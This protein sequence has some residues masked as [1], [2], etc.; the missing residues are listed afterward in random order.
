MLYFEKVKSTLKKGCDVQL[1]PRTVI[2]GPNGSGKSTIVQSIE[3]AANGWASDMEGRSR[4]KQSAALARLFPGSPRKAEAVMSDGT[5]FS[6]E[7]ED[8]TRP[9]SFKKPD[10]T[11]PFSVRWPVQDLMEVLRGDAS[12][13]GAWLEKQVVGDL[14]EED[15]LSALPPAVRGVVADFVQQKSQ[16]DFIALAKMANQQAK[17]LRSQATRSEKTIEKMTEGIAPPLLDSKRKELEESLAAM[18]APRHGSTQEDYDLCAAEVQELVDKFVEKTA[19]LEKLSPLPEAVSVALERLVAAND[20]IKQHKKVFGGDE[21]WVCG[22]EQRLEDQEARLGVAME[23]LKPQ[24]LESIN[25]QK[26]QQ[27][28]STL[29]K[30]MERKASELKGMEVVDPV[31]DTARRD[32]IAKIAADDSNRKSWSNADAAGKEVEQMRAKADLL[33]LAGGALEKAGKKFLAQR[34]QAFEDRVSEHLPEGER[35]GVDLASSR[36]G[37][38]RDGQLHSAL[39]GAEWSRVLLALSAAQHGAGST[40]C[41]VVPEDRA[42]DADTLESVMVALADAPVQVIIMSTV[43]PN[44]VEGWTLINT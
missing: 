13:V 31:D 10:P 18:T 8:G 7:L 42:W 39:S 3:L 37:L 12:T 2:C 24:Y 1:G 16:T 17:N 5:V 28:L 41:V 11:Q 44:P 33:S 25:R 30:E 36:V 4:V 21:C 35:L 9:G 27:D 14:T 6:W 34:K 38:V 43:V 32:I 15:L 20:L 22:S 19:E 26:V 29:Q 40:P 23:E